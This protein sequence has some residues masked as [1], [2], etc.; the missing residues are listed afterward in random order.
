MED[1]LTD[2]ERIDWLRAKA[3][4]YLPSALAGLAIAFALIYGWRQYHS[5]QDNQALNAGQKY[6]LGLD[7]L[8]RGDHE[9]AVRIAAEL[10]SGYSRAPYV[11]LLELAIARFDVEQSKLDEAARRLEALEKGA[12]DPDLRTIARLR[13]ARVERAEGKP[14]LALAT[15]AGGPAGGNDP[16]YADVRGDVL[17]DKGDKS[18][19]LTAWRAALEA[20]TPGAINRELVELKI[21]ALGVPPA[22]AT[23]AATATGGGKP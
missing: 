22:A 13:L 5:W 23:P 16:A 8:S 18:G 10:K 9:G 6:A 12:R 19:A 1:Y 3:K 21:A 4:E 2:R 20:K 14:D 17:A 15:L 11:D 7:A